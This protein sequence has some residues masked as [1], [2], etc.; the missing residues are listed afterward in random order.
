MTV[1][2]VDPIPALEQLA[3]AATGLAGELRVATPYRAKEM[4]RRIRQLHAAMRT[5]SRELLAWSEN[6]PGISQVEL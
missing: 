5:A 1:R 4:A 3:A 2:I 6:N